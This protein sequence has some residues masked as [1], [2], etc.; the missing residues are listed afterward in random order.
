[1]SDMANG[2]VIKGGKVN[3]HRALELYLSRSHLARRQQMVQWIREHPT[4]FL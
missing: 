1:M 3:F 2:E 4:S